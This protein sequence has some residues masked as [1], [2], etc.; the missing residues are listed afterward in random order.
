M[1]LP[2]I[3]EVTLG[4]IV[5]YYVLGAI[6]SLVTQI[7]MESQQARGVALESLLKKMAGPLTLDIMN[8][9][10]IKT[11]EPIRYANWWNVFGAGTEHKKV[12]KIP[13]ETLVDAFFDL[14]GLTSHG[15]LDAEELTA[16]VGQLPNSEGK[17]AMLAWIGQGV[18]SLSELRNR[19]SAY[20]AGVL[21]QAALIFKAKARSFVIIASIVITVLFG[22]DTLQTAVDLSNDAAL[23]SSAAQ[24]AQA[25]AAQP[26]STT[27]LSGRVG[28]LNALSFQIGWWRDQ[29]LPA[30]APTD[31]WVKFVLLKLIG[32]GIT[33]AAVSQGSSFWYDILKRLTGTS[34]SPEVDSGASAAGGAAG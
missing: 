21:N 2:Q 18:T 19:T 25:T 3:I 14:S 15:S 13:V 9:P 16:L 26:E 17:Q 6:V 31:E 22:V 30:N 27:G 24:Q 11:L 4:L 5:I 33:A 23:R 10:Q 29:G 34:S 32:L 28:E 1:S 12:E 20:A 7:A 8:L